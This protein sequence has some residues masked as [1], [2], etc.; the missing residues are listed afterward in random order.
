[1]PFVEIDDVDDLRFMLPEELSVERC[2]A[3]VA[4]VANVTSET[5][6]YAELQRICG[7]QAEQS[8]WLFAY[9]E[10]PEKIA[11]M[12][13]E[14]SEALEAFRAGLDPDLVVYSEDKQGMLKP[15]GLGIELAD[16]VIRIMHYCE[17]MGIPLD[18]LIQIKL[19][20]NSS[21]PYRH[22]DLRA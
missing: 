10:T 11:L 17:G 9:R 4:A 3:Q 1:M 13:S 19:L 22:G 6:T 7:V 5:P 12:H 18:K 16:T 20:Y 8:G 14:L 21:R 15:E 2:E